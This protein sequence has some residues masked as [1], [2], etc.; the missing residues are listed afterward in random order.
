MGAILLHAYR[1]NVSPP[2]VARPEALSGETTL[3]RLVNSGFGSRANFRDEYDATRLSKAGGGSLAG[4][5]TNSADTAQPFCKSD[6]FI[7]AT[8]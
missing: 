3:L 8:H 7:E 4:C 5:D 6:L 1:A 2:M